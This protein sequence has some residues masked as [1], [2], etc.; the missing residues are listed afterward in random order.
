MTSISVVQPKIQPAACASSYQQSIGGQQ[1]SLPHQQWMLPNPQPQPFGFGVNMNTQGGDFPFL[2]QPPNFNQNKRQRMAS[3]LG[4]TS[5]DDGR[6][7]TPT[8]SEFIK[9]IK[10]WGIQFFK[11]VELVG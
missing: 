7:V 1:Q 8:F 9:S 11:V 10:S 6:P 3:D 5:A 4:S 2:Q